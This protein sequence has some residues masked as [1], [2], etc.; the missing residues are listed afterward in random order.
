MTLPKICYI[1]NIIGLNIIGNKI[2]VR[3]GVQKVYF[4]SFFRVLDG[5]NELFALLDV[6]SDNV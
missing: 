1:L 2:F 3:T 6:I 5:K 4:C